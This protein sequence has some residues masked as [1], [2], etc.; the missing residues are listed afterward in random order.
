MGHQDSHPPKARWCDNLCPRYSAQTHVPPSPSNPHHPPPP[1]THTLGGPPFLSTPLPP[2][3]ATTAAPAPTALAP[4]LLLL[5]PASAASGC[6]C[7]ACCFAMWSLSR[8]LCLNTRSQW[9]HFS[10][11]PRL[12][13]TEGPLEPPPAPDLV[14][15]VVV[16]CV[17]V[18]WRGVVL[19]GEGVRSAYSGA[20]S[21]PPC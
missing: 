1:P 21:H 20:A 14:L 18:C 2:A 8:P 19:G 6:S 5:P 15:V 11:W 17:E 9:G 10:S 13:S 4:L 7:S 16:V 12:S 3:P